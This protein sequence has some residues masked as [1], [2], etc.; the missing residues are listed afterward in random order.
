MTVQEAI[1]K[2]QKI[3]QY[4]PSE[5]KEQ[6]CKDIDYAL[7]YLEGVRRDALLGGPNFDL[8][9]DIAKQISAADDRLSHVDITWSTQLV[10]AVLS[11]TKTKNSAYQEVHKQAKQ[12]SEKADKRHKLLCRVGIALF[13]AVGI[14][15]IVLAIFGAKFGLE[16]RTVDIVV[17]VCGLADFMMGGVGFFVERLSDIKAKNVKADI[18]QAAQECIAEIDK[19]TTVEGVEKVKEKYIKI[20]DQSQHG[21]LNIQIVKDDTEEWDI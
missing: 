20:I 12:G 9:N 19:Q 17:S 18:A 8:S 15:A 21:L 2:L 11:L 3:K 13:V 6:I 10:S 7:N 4:I 14:V 5:D 16:E 1:D